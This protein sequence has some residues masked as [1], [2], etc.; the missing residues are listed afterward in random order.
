MVPVGGRKVGLADGVCTGVGKVPELRLAGLRVVQPRRNAAASQVFD[1][2]GAAC[3]GANLVLDDAVGEEFGGAEGQVE[4]IAN[5]GVV[6]TAQ[7]A[8]DICVAVAKGYDGFDGF[9]V[10]L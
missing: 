5:V 2:V 8:L 1:P 7:G 4:G 6:C 10:E 9:P 3:G